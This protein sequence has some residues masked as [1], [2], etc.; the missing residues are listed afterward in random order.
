MSNHAEKLPAL[1]IELKAAGVYLTQ[2][3][4]HHILRLVNKLKTLFPQASS[5]AICLKKETQRPAPA[6]TVTICFGAPGPGMIA[7]E[8]GK[9]WEVVLKN[10]EIKLARQRQKE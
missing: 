8:S 5:I 9:R 4:V 2:K 7:S 1:K 6:K 3:L 10:L